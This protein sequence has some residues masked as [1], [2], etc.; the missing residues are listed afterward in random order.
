MRWHFTWFHL[1]GAA[2]NLDVQPFGRGTAEVF[3]HAV[4][5]FG[6]VVRYRLVQLHP[7]VYHNAAVPEVEDFQLPESSQIGL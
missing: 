6:H 4:D 1:Q 2:V 3:Q 5:G 7:A